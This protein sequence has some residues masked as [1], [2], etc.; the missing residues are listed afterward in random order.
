MDRVEEMRGSGPSTGEVD[1]LLREYF[2]AALPDPWPGPPAVTPVRAAR[3]PLPW[4]RSTRLA[5]AAS[6]LVAFTGYALVAG[7]FPDETR[8]GLD[9][10]GKGMIGKKSGLEVRTPSGRPVELHETELPGGGFKI[11]VIQLPGTRSPR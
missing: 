6:V 11:E 10:T 9:F 2:K 7:L 1:R 4:W 8:P 3:T 5:L